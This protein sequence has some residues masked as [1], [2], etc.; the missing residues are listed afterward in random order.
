MSQ[1]ELDLNRSIAGNTASSVASLARQQRV[2]DS[3][4]ANR[5]AIRA[6]KEN[7][8]TQLYN[9]DAMNRQAVAAQNAQT[10]NAYNTARNQFENE[11]IQALANNRTSMIDS[12]IGAY[13]DYQTGVDTR[14]S[15]RLR[16]AAELAKNPEQ[17]D[18]FFKKQ[19]K[20]SGILKNMDDLFN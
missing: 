17:A 20:Y 3:S 12:I 1:T 16:L 14:R 9:Q 19:K 2:S 8:E 6:N 15:E 10:T 18:L 11:K 4:L 7:I 13:R 5:N